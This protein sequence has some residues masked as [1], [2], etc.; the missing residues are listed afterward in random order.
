MAK[1]RYRV[2]KGWDVLAKDLGISAQDILR[3]AQ[4]PLDLFSN[5]NAT[6]DADEYFRLWNALGVVLRD[7]PTFPL[8]VV[9]AF[10]AEAFNPPL[11]ACYC[12][13][14]LNIAAKRIAYYKPLIGPMRLDVRQNSKQTT[15]SFHGLPENAAPPP[16][17]IAMELA[18]WV[19]ITRRATRENIVPL[20][21]H[22]TI[23]IPELDEYE[24]Y[25]GTR[26]S[27]ATF[28]GVTFSAHDANRPFLTANEAMWDIFEP[29]LNKRMKDLEADS[30]F[31]DRVRACLMEIL[32]SGQYSM[33]DVASRLAIS[34]RTLQRRLKSEGTTFQ[35]ELDNLREEL[36]RNYLSKSEYSSG[37]IAFLLGYEDPN[38]FFRAFRAWTGQTPEYTRTALRGSQ[39]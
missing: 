19:H 33:A 32:A 11:F 28:N 1:Q 26:V 18:F 15:I 37:Q 21:V 27:K 9:Q 12:S 20:A 24:H 6:L 4:L 29:Q 5:K 3:S 30:N 35:K 7:N 39:A 14:N 22:T 17:L 23:N 36:A 25:F 34:P 13:E 31:R 38:S 10:T 8:T 2:D 16:S